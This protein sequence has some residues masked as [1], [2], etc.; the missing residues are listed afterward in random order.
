MKSARLP[1]DVYAGVFLVLLGAAFYFLALEL[2]PEAAVFPKMVLGTFI[3]LAAGMAVQGYRKFKKT[4]EAS[5]PLAFDGI[6][7]PLLIFVFITFYVVAMDII[8]FCL[9]TAAFIPGV[10][11]FYR[12]KKPLH[13]LAA[14]GCLIGFIYLLFVVQLQLV[15]P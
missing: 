2:T 4:G 6:K 3:L 15:L 1:M 8:G 10:A 11:L 5:N 9:A 13:I 7:I 14:T 12:N